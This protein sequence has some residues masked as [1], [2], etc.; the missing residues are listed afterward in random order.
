M[1]IPMIRIL[2]AGALL[3]HGIGHTL[4][5]WKPAH[6]MLFLKVSDQVLRLAG[7]IIWV[8]VAV[9]FVASAMSFFGVL[10]PANWWRPLAVVFAAISLVG[11]L[12][13]GRSWPLFNFIGASGMNIIVLMALLWLHWPPFEM[14]NR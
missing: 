14:F 1:S 4:G 10:A 11:L 13:F 5:F 6:S 8:L 7:G 2:I 9:G 12:L 3:V